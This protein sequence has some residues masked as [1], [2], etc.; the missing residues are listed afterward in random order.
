[1]TTIRSAFRTLVLIALAGLVVSAQQPAVAPPAA[2]T[3]ASVGVSAERLARLHAGMQGFIDRKEAGGIVTLIARDGK[4]V[5]VHAS[6]FQDVAAK[7]PMRTDTMFRIASMTK[8]VTS[9]ALMMLYEEGK[10]LLTDPVSK[11]IPAFKSSRVLEGAA[12]AP[13]PARRGINLR[14]LLSHRSGLTYGFLNGGPVGGGYRKNGVTDGLTV[15]SMTLAEAIDKLAAEP[16]IS[17]P[18]AAWNYSLSTDVLGRVVEVASGQPF[19]VFLRERIFK[20]LRMADT[21]FAVPD[22][23]WSRMATVYSPDGAAGIR[24]MTD[25]ESFGNTVMSPMASYKAE[26]KTYY[27]GGAGL[28]STA[29]DYARFGQMLLNGGVLDGAR[30]LSPKT[31]EL[32]TIS[33]TADLPASGLIGNGAQFGLGFRVVTDVGA[34]QTLGSNGIYGWSGIYGTVF[35]VDPKERLVAVMLVQRY[36]GSAVAGA[37]QPL[38][39]QSL[40]K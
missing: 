39:Y 32:M 10:L 25:P 26:G 30:L 37:F 34:T 33:H 17:Q 27:S 14:D 35:W 16:L 40:V 2:A 18:G 23:K 3:P 19:Q 12:E 4:V 24:P 13:V 9:I 6:G 11:F 5:D 8:P 28:V 38:V 7:T 22:A 36:P 29:R 20:P 31:V 1:M 21:D 15:T